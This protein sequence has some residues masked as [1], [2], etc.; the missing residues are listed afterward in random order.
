[1][2]NLRDHWLVDEI[3]T[4][5]GSYQPLL[6]ISFSEDEVVTSPY[7]L[8]VPPVGRLL[9]VPANTC[10]A[11][12]LTPGALS[13]Y[14]AGS[15]RLRVRGAVYEIRFVD[16]RRRYTELPEIK[17][18]TLEAY[19]VRL[20]LG[21]VW[22]VNRPDLVIHTQGALAALKSAWESAGIDF[23]QAHP[24]DGLVSAPGAVP[25]EGQEI[26]R[27][28]RK[29]LEGSQACRGFQVLDVIILNRQ[30]DSRRAEAYQ[31]AAVERAEIQ[32]AMLVQSERA[33]MLAES[34][35][36]EQRRLEQEE[37]LA[38]QQARISRRRSE[39][40]DLRRIR[41][42]EISVHE[43][44]LL[45]DVKLQ[46]I[47]LQ[48]VAN[49]QYL[50]HEQVLKSLDVRAQAFGQLAGA[51]MQ[52][53][54][55]SGVQRILSQDERQGL[56]RALELL[57]NMPAVPSD[58]GLPAPGPPAASPAAIDDRPMSLGE[59]LA[60]ELKEML[61]IPGISLV[62]LV[63]IGMGAFGIYLSHPNLNFVIEV[64][65]GYPQKPPRKV[66]LKKGG[67]TAPLQVSRRWTAGM[68]LSHVVLT[69]IDKTSPDAGNPP[70]R[71][72]GGGAEPTRPVAR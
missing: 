61:S 8:D 53:L 33:R 64:D 39:E 40:E 28:I 47:Q 17:A 46:E 44:R 10:A 42:A 19:T 48:Q 31:R 2:V 41:S 36:Q 71:T 63:S 1:M 54:T 62:K 25:I 60:V 20:R 67:R 57:G 26:A 5:L 34:Q 72:N 24:H 69:V 52:N 13:F 35:Q 50:Q 9:R 23:I 15:H 51:L 66:L 49:A 18:A 12:T 30:G 55:A 3:V 16:L 4:L 59:R 38:V 32:Q 65:D 21:V 11:L 29:A 43:A 6:S 22:C 45:R 68:T 58:L 14:P 70:L 7:S 56:I 27:A 37:I